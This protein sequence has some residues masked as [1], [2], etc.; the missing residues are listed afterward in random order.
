MKK[1]IRPTIKL[2]V[3]EITLTKEK[4]MT[5]KVLALA[6]GIAALGSGLAGCASHTHSQKHADEV[7]VT[8]EVHA[9]EELNRSIVSSVSFAKGQKGL[10]PEATSEIQKALADARRLGKIK[11]VEVAVWSD[12]EYPKKGK[13]LP[14][15]QIKLANERAKNVEKLIDQVEPKS[16]IKTFNMAKQ[17]NAFQKWVDTR[18]AHIK[19]KLASTGITAAEGVATDRASSALVFIE[20]E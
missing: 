3:S 11:T 16:T 13:S 6:L 19:Q 7:R 18:D 15:K 12:M 20:V 8:K 9:A 17:P 10:T 4:T 5:V 1:F 2:L 14:S